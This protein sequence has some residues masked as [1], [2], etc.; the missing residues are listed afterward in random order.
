MKRSV[1]K[2]FEY[3]IVLNLPGE[4]CWQLEDLKHDFGM[5]FGE[6]EDQF[7]RPLVPI[8]KTLLHVS[9]EQKLLNALRRVGTEVQDFDMNLQGFDFFEHSNT[10]FVDVEN[11]APAINLHHIVTEQLYQENLI[12]KK[13]LGDYV[14]HVAIGSQLT[15]SQY[16][17]AYHKF[18]R[19][20]FANYFRVN[21]LTVL[22]RRIDRYPWSH[23]TDVPLTGPWPYQPY[24]TAS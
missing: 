10:C 1:P 17:N 3:S 4:I 21:Q 22:T 16:R 14:P 9:D 13:A 19:K 8:V 5:R 23:L 24:R 18:T 11:K 15:D 7:K 2:L 20:M 6:Y 12:S